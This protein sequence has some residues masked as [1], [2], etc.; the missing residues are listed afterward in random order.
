MT[1]IRANRRDMLRATAGFAGASLLGVLN[2]PSALAA[3]MGKVAGRSEKPLKAAFSNIGLQVSWCA[4]GKQAAEYWGKLFNVDVTWF[5]G[6]L[7]DAKQRTAIEDMANQKW[8]FVAIQPFSIDTL[9]APV[10]KMIKAGVPVIDMDTLIAPLDEIDVHSFLAPDNEFMGA[11]VTQVLMDQIGG[12]G[13][14]VMTQGALGHTGAQGR[15]RGFWNVVKKYPKME[16]V[17]TTPADWDVTKVASIWETLLTKFPKIDAAYFHND[18]MALAAYEVMKAH[19][20]SSIKI[21]GC[22][23]MPPALQAVT[24]GRMVATVRN[25]SCLIHGGAIIAG[26]TAIVTGEKT[27]KGPGMIPK[28]VVT[29]GPVVTKANAPGLVWME[30]HFLI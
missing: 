21:G 2:I 11:A 14:V 12:E 20:R 3:E 1:D 25:P 4:Q 28:H 6:E 30:E 29:D 26:V 7:S 9:T 24:D 10:E 8:D 17:D 15:A 22:D 13:I 27:G 16:V 18:D 23:A 5:D 19:N